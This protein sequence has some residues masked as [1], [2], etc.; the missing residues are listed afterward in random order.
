MTVT[1]TVRDVPEQ[2]RDVLAREARNRG[3]SLQAF[4][5][6]VLQQQARFAENRQLLWEVE[7]ELT[8]EGGGEV[9]PET[10]VEAIRRERERLPPAHPTRGPRSGQAS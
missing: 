7:E 10:I 2:T 5:L 9:D 1:V 3:Q 8:A 4:L 6:S